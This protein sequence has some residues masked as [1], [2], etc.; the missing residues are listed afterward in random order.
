MQTG[1]KHREDCKRVFKAYDMGCARCVELSN[2]AEA[3]AGW[4]DSKNR[5]DAIRSANIDKHFINHNQTC[6]YA[7]RGVPCVAFD[8]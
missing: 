8:W 2:G 1:T 3:R 7:K 4:N 5:A 6:D